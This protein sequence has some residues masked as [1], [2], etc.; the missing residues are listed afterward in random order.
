MFGMPFHSITT[1]FAEWYR[2]ISLRSLC[3]ENQER[4]F[5]D[6]KSTTPSTNFQK[7]HLQT[8][9]LIRNQSRARENMLGESWR[10]QESSIA[11]EWRFL[12]ARPSTIITKRMVEANVALFAAHKARISDYLLEGIWHTETDDGNWIFKDGANDSVPDETNLVPWHIR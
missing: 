2:L 3:A 12:P 10:L 8:N 7:G 5:K 9:A 6:I 1:H 11:K 4:F